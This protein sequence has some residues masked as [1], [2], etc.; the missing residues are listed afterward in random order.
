[1][2]YRNKYTGAEVE[3]NSVVSGGGWEPVSGNKPEKPKTK[4]PEKTKKTTGK[5]KK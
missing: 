4:T 2:L 3:V 5:G 1:M